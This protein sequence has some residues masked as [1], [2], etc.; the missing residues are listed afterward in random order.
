M[1][2]IWSKVD[3]GLYQSPL[4]NIIREHDG[5]F[6]FRAGKTVAGPFSTRFAAQVW[7]EM[8]PPQAEEIAS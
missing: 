1:R 6:A 8:H 2:S 5:W 7:V 4:G 3:V